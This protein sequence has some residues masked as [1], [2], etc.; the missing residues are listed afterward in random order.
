MTNKQVCWGV[1]LV[2][3]SI[4]MLELIL[5]RI[6]SVTMYY[7]FAFLAISLALFGSGASGI[8]V[9][10]LAKLFRK[11]NAHKHMALSA[12]LSAIS[13]IT[14][15][16]VLLKVDLNLTTF[17]GNYL[18]LITVYIVAAMPF[19]FGGLSI[20]VALTH[21]AEQ[22]SRVYF[23][24]LIGASLGCL[25]VIPSL[26][27]LGGPTAM[28]A[29]SLPMILAAI[30]FAGSTAFYRKAA[31]AIFVLITVLLVCDYKGQF[32]AITNAKGEDGKRIIMQKWNSFSRVTVTGDPA[33][34][35][36]LQI[37]IDSD[38]ATSVKRFEPSN[39]EKY[40]E[41]NSITSLGYYLKEGQEPKVLIIGP[42]GGPDVSNALGFG[43]SKVT[44]VEINPIIAND[45]MRDKFKDYSG[46]LYEHP[47]VEIVV[48]E[49]R[50][51]IRS[52]NEKYDVIQATLV[53]TWAATSAGAF[54]LT[55]N[56]LYT[57]E[58][59][60]DYA[61]HLSPTGLLTMTRWL[62]DPPQQEL[63]LI[64]LTWSMMEEF[65]IEDPS[66]HIMIVKDRGESDRLAV[67]FI[68]KRSPFLDEE[69]EKMLEVC[70]KQGFG[71][72]YLPGYPQKN[73]FTELITTKDPE[74]IYKT[75]PLNITPTYDNSPFFFN[76][77]R[78]EDYK[79][80][81]AL[82]Y[83]SQKTNLGMFVLVTLFV[84][85]LV[86][87][88][89][90][91]LAPLLIFR[92]NVIKDAGF[93]RLKLI[94]YFACLGMGFITV[95]ISL[96]QKFTL[97]LGH[98]VYSLAVILFSLLLF[99]SIGSY[100]TGKFSSETLA[101]SAQKI[102]GIIWIVVLL[103]IAILPY[104]FYNY[105][106]LPLPIKVVVAVVFLAPLAFLMGMPMPIGIRI[107]NQQATALIP[108][109]W[110][111]NGATSVL[112]SVSTFILAISFGFNQS[113][114]VGLFIYA[115]AGLLLIRQDRV[116]VE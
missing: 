78:L 84:I 77:V 29:I 46:R 88:A 89:L 1:M 56:N 6:F 41:E 67:S 16:L 95:E 65:K 110:G 100:T 98:P 111:V 61:S 31:W 58:A 102:I 92:R 85:T 69:V 76:N 72:L 4:L 27:L 47:K 94:F 82:N 99:S 2:S 8:Y 107:T 33:R 52:T 109:A 25:L 113:L 63:R 60:K 83:E 108:W 34:D 64:S 50:S 23:Y 71:P 5:T 54:A 20:S 49:G 48:D 35:S 55:E 96:I 81:F 101:E 62:L 3:L 79:K 13:I 57:V 30:L 68:F 87:V 28:L 12:I 59:F 9:Y 114:L 26:N 21:Y 40:K 37:K 45:I 17:E 19:F 73:I 43:A 10:L 11:E 104:I 93:K 103:Y 86:L 24:D 106:S 91:L 22:I 39:L 51:Y 14:A 18:R 42:G 116:I 80:A 53:D 15:L 115:L 97:F 70:K 112:G 105:V 36:Y 44:G 66:R 75:Y 32:F 74:A 38:A 90:F 7:H